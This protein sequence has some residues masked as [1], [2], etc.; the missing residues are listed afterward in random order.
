MKIRTI[1]LLFTQVVAIITGSAKLYSAA[2]PWKEFYN[3]RE[4]GAERLR[5][6]PPFAYV[7]TLELVLAFVIWIF[8]GDTAWSMQYRAG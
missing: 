5:M 8:L 2:A 7:G 1:Y 6:E 3:T 4:P